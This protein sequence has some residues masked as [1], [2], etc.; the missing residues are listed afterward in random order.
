[1]RV[2]A[3]ADFAN[4]IS[5]VLDPSQW[6]FVNADL[7]VYCHRQPTSEWVALDSQSVV[8]PFAVGCTLSSLYDI[9][10]PLGW[11]QQSLLIDRRSP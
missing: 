1:M 6:S 4:G 3:V 10:G 8:S 11:S 2:M 7:T 5:S 9:T